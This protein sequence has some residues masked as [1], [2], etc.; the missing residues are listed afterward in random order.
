MW[1]ASVQS[2][3]YPTG[4]P[5]ARLGLRKLLTAAQNMGV[6]ASKPTTDDGQTAKE[7]AQQIRELREEVARLQ[8]YVKKAQELE[9]YR[10]KVAELEPYLERV[11]ELEP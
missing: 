3:Q 2:S 4:K 5:S 9:P 7:Q 11:K 8:P 6:C 10:E 1:Q